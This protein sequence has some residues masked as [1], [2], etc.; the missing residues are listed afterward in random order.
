MPVLCRIRFSLRTE[1]G[2]KPKPLPFMWGT[3]LEERHDNISGELNA[4][5]ELMTEFLRD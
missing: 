1:A 5:L 4:G 3:D 2:T